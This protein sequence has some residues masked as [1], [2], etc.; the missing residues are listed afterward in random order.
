[1]IIYKSIDYLP[2]YNYIKITEGNLKYLYK[3]DNYEIDIEI[4]EELT[5]TL[6]LIEQQVEKATNSNNSQLIRLKLLRI[7]RIKKIKQTLENCTFLLAIKN[8]DEV[9]D[10]LKSLNYSFNKDNRQKEIERLVGEAKNL[11][12][13]IDDIEGN[14][15]EKDLSKVEEFNLFKM[16]SIIENFKQI[17]IDVHTLPTAKYIVYTN[18]IKEKANGK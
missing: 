1:M 13:T 11:Q 12:Q 8:D 18:E 14:I 2:I 3:L 4:T 10:I 9:I 5:D 15:I 17:S 6:E 7:L 16:I